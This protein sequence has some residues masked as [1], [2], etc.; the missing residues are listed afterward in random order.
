MLIVAIA[1]VQ[2]SYLLSHG[3]AVSY[4]GSYQLL[5]H[6]S[7]STDYRLNVAVSQSLQ[8]YYAEKNRRMSSDDD[9]T[10][11]VTPYALAP[12]AD[13]LEGIYSDDEDFVNGALMF[14]HQ[15]PYE[16]TVP[17]KYPVET[18]VDNKGD[19]DLFSYVVA[20]I[21]KARG[22]DVVLLYY[23]SE[24]HMNIGVSLS[25]PPVDAR[26]TAFSVTNNGVR[27]YVAECTGGNWQNG[28]RVGECPDTLRQA[29]VQVVTLENCEQSSPGQV[30]A[31]LSTL[32]TSSI[33]LSVTPS[34]LIQ[35]SI[36]T[37]S[38]QLSPALQNKTITIY[39]KVN[40]L[41]WAGLATV[42]TDSDGRF[43]YAWV[44]EAGGVEYVRAS[45]SGDGSYAGAD[46]P[47][48]IVTVLSTFFVI[49]L[50]LIIVFVAAGVAIAIIS[51]KAQQ[52]IQAPQPPEIP[53]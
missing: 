50:G 53:S 47:A 21:V 32:S 33:S 25:H 10:K 7:G 2:L 16:V 11:F 39:V 27:Y 8:D 38:G 37:V 28:W 5:E 46:S 15:I 29:S 24:V 26:D 22:L 49:L 17:S 9:F 19:C 31:S 14:V 18:I 43:T 36:A 44:P 20:S 30:A 3:L 34:S 23:E 12:I 52:E 13:C 40:G 1:L 4:S 6:G 45:W 51:R 48:E 41:S 35:G 42:T